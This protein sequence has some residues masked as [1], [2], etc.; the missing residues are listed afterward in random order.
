MR[1]LRRIHG[2]P[3]LA[4]LPRLLGEVR[5]RGYAERAPNCMGGTERY[6]FLIDNFH[7]VAVP[8]LI[9]REILCCINLL[10]RPAAVS[11]MRDKAKL[12]RLLRHCA[13]KIASNYEAQFPTDHFEPNARQPI[14]IGSG[15]ALR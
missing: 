11:N 13:Q 12:A 1:Q 6:P 7:A 4:N 15:P 2:A 9:R 3:A 8:V 5:E 14:G 10:W